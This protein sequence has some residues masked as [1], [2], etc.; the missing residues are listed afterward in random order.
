MSL[1][2]RSHRRGTLNTS[3]LLAFVFLCLLGAF[4]HRASWLGP[5][6]SVGNINDFTLAKEESFGFFDDIPKKDW[7]RRKALSRTRMH[8]VNFEPR[9]FR[10][11][12]AASAPYHQLNWDPDFSCS[13]KDLVGDKW[14]C[15]PHR[16]ENQPCLVLSVGPNPD[17]MFERA[18]AKMHPHCEIHT[19]DPASREMEDLP[20]SV[21]HHAIGIKPSY[22]M[23]RKVAAVKT[24]FMQRRRWDV[25]EKTLGELQKELKLQDRQVSILSVDCT[26]CEWYTYKDF[27]KIGAQQMVL[28]MH[29][30]PGNRNETMFD[31]HNAGYVIVHK[32]PE[33]DM[34][35]GA[36]T[37][38]TMVKLAKS[39]FE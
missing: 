37:Q 13:F 14:L 10:G 6:S 23:N 28:E 36:Y 19:F 1:V 29:E 30:T 20:P 17:F 11:H 26:G 4:L 18:L 31:M 3:L 8:D 27:L 22:E 32:D 12:I 15:D 25:P 38:Y 33:F 35:G 34:S 7:L 16:L 2:K 21:H 24:V 5:S 9:T 39:F